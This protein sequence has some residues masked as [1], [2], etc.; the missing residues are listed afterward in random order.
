MSIIRKIMAIEDHEQVSVPASML[1]QI[2]EDFSL[3]RDSPPTTREG[4]EAV[5]ATFD[6]IIFPLNML[7]PV[8]IQ[9]WA[10]VETGQFLVWFM[11]G[12]RPVSFVSNEGASS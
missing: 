4:L 1:A 9:T 8:P 7:S 3:F 5:R 11:R 2:E 10:A 6:A 12:D